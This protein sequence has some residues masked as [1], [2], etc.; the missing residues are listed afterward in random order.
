MLN[1][2]QHMGM[3]GFELYDNDL[4]CDVKKIFV[5][6]IY[7]GVSCSEAT[8]AVICD[9][10]ECLQ[11]SEDRPIVWITLADTQ[12][13]MG[14]L[15]KSVKTRALNEIEKLNNADICDSS[16]FKLI[17]EKDL[18]NIKN[19]LN[20]PMPPKIKIKKQ[21]SR[22][23]PSF[24]EKG[25]VFRV[26]LTMDNLQYD[27]TEY[28]KNRWIMMQVTD[29]V[30][31]KEKSELFYRPVMRAYISKDNTMPSI[32]QLSELEPIV[33][34]GGSKYQYEYRFA[35][36]NITENNIKKFFYCGKSEL[37][38]SNTDPA[39]DIRNIMHFD[40]E[41]LANELAWYYYYL[42]KELNY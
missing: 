12:W 27:S 33:I 11:D 29:I 3:I 9:F 6:M 4:A 28:L 7:S 24:C 10:E 23:H 5:D 32:F 39:D 41:N 20:M 40:I 14:L 30:P 42:K 21:I 15:L 38:S 37:L 25:D 18:N 16:E 34:G 36:I 22:T 17:F 35:M 2:R 26:Q 13:E 31:E 19:K 8:A 1:G